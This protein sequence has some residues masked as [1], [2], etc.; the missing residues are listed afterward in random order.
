MDRCEDTGPH[1]A[2]TPEVAD[3]AAIHPPGI[4][5]TGKFHFLGE[6]VVLEPRQQFEVHRDTLIAILRGMH[7]QVVHGGNQQTV[8][9]VDDFCILTV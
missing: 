2:E 7:V 8:A 6:G 5:Q 4:V 1:G 9:E 3:K